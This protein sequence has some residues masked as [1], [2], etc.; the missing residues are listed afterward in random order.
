M[1]N[2][3]KNAFQ[4]L[5]TIALFSSSIFADGEMGGGG[6]PGLVADN[7]GAKAAVILTEEDGEMGGGGRAADSDYL[8]TVIRSI[9]DYF[10]WSI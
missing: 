1:K 10:D 5:V 6:R 3:K 7:A 4:A 9:Y 8:E 2:I